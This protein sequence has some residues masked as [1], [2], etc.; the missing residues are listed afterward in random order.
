MK[1][2]KKKIVADESMHPIAV[3]IDYEDWQAIE[4]ILA[5]YQQS[6]VQPTLADYAG[7][8]QLTIAPLELSTA[9]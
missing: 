8:I 4:K 6:D 3:L 7:V 2:I 1:P 9:N 5:N